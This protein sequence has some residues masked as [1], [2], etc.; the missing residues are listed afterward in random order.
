ML[1]FTDRFVKSLK[2]RR[3]GWRRDSSDRAPASKYKALNSNP[4]NT[5][6]K[7]KRI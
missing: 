5:K 2:N 3:K 7:D 6:K 1:I 4:N